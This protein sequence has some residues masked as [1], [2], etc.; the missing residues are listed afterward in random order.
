MFNIRSDRLLFRSIIIQ[1]ME[2]G[3]WPRK[4]FSKNCNLSFFPFEFEITKEQMH[5]SI[6]SICVY[7]LNEC[8]L[9]VGHDTMRKNWNTRFFSVFSVKSSFFSM[10][11]WWDIHCQEV[12]I[13]TYDK[14]KPELDSSTQFC[15]K[16]QSSLSKHQMS[17]PEISGNKMIAIFIILKVQIVR[18]RFT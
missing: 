14:S 11:F 17:P 4:K 9:Y 13:L 6:T 18:N 12:S 2:P 10:G 16:V 15:K 8:E 7:H 1:R 5:Q 3:K